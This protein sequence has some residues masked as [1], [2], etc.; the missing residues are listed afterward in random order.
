M[1]APAVD[2]L[3]VDPTRLSI[4][5]LLSSSRWVEFGFVRDT[6]GLSDSALSKQISKLCDQGYVEVERGYVGKRP[7]TWINLTEA[8]KAALLNHVAALQAIVDRSQQA[9]ESH[10]EGTPLPR[11]TGPSHP[12]DPRMPA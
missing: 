2:S 5:S 10:K 11:T 3:L 7:R 4:V 12:A 8:G 6:V 1:A 9:G